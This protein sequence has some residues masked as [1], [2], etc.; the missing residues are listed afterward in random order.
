MNKNGSTTAGTTR[1]RCTTCGASET[2]KRPDITHTAT[3]TTFLDYLT[4][5]HTLKHLATS[6]NTSTRT[7][8]RRFRNYW[9]ITP[10]NP[11]AAH[12]GRIYDQIFIDG[13]YLSGNCL[14]I[15]TSLDHVLSWHWCKTE[16]AH[17]Y[18]QLFTGICPPLI[19]TTDGG[20]GARKAIHNTWPTARIQ[21]CLIHVQRNLRT[22]TTRRPKT[23]AGKA[24]YELSKTL[25]RI[26]NGDQA[27]HW[28]S[29]LQHFHTIYGHWIDETTWTTDPLTRK[30]T[31]TYTHQRIRTAY[32]S[33]EKLYK[34]NVLF[35]YLDPPQTT[36][37]PERLKSTTNTLEGGINAE[38]K[39]LANAHRGLTLEHQR[40][41][42]DWWLY[43]KTQLPDDPLEIARQCNFGQDQLAKVTDLVPEDLNKADQQTGRPAFY[44]Q[45]IDVEYTHSIGI[46]K[47]QI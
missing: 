7:L 20:S 5:T 13:T 12:T 26:T 31:K 3:F 33:L 21:R 19:V 38:V 9:L 42:I 24:L 46:R 22:A 11:T 27:A 40:R 15:A 23:P 29:Q 32:K 47:G 39:R 35:T 4:T 25:T 36:L 45:G 17:A 14:L 44:D 10:P 43:L 41:M 6:K 1:W 28:I 34:H 16:T 8:Q 2:K 18:Q 30:T 37:Q